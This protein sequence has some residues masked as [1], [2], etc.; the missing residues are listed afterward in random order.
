MDW[1]LCVCEFNIAPESLYSFFDFL[2]CPGFDNSPSPKCKTT[3]L[4]LLRTKGL[5]K[6]GK[7]LLCDYHV[8]QYCND[9]EQGFLN[10]N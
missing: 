8:F 9:G 4:I 1:L 10:L 5:V 3:K 2:S 7:G 6:E